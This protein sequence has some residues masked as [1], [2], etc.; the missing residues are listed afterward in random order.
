MR[1]IDFLGG[2]T[3]LIFL[4]PDD[5]V[6]LFYLEALQLLWPLLAVF[7]FIFSEIADIC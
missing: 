2:V 5:S 4:F 7:L 1:F 3:T 6:F